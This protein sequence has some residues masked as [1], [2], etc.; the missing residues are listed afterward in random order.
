[1]T[2]L[3]HKKTKTKNTHDKRTYHIGKINT[4]N[5]RIYRFPLAL[6][7]LFVM[8]AFSLSKL[9]QLLKLV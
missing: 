5:V 9:A 8:G 1:M 6:T 3:G 2:F 7:L 4:Y